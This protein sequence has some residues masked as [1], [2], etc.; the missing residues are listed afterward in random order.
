MPDDTITPWSQ[1]FGEDPEPD[2]ILDQPQPP[3][4]R[5][6]A[7]LHA[8]RRLRND[9]DALRDRQ[10]ASLARHAVEAREDEALEIYTRQRN[11]G[12][13]PDAGTRVMAARALERAGG[14]GLS[15]AEQLAAPT[16][17]RLRR[18][19]RDQ[20]DDRRGRRS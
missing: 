2:Q 1:T 9:Q 13:T 8:A 6:S 3:G 7:A 20:D 15:S 18:Q 17:R 19:A 5:S 12:H 14:S 11:A 10:Q 4:P 16:L